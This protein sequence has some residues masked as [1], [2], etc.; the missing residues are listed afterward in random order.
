[1]GYRA[2]ALSQ[3]DGAG[4]EQI[5]HDLAEQLG[6]GYLNEAVI[7][8]VAAD[9]GIDTSMVGDAERRRSFLERLAPA[10]AFAGVEG[11]LPDVSMYAMYAMDHADTI[12]GF[13]RAAVREAADRGKVVLVS[14][15]AC[16]ACADHPDV[17]RVCATAS[18]PT[19]ASR[20][21]SDRGISQKDSIKLL[22]Q[23]D[24]GRASYLKRV[25]GVESESPTD[26]DIVVNTDRLDPDAAITAI[27]A[28]AG[29]DGPQN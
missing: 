19:R 22:R 20:V 6:F 9:Q 7:A 24:A 12:L 16:Y 23:S 14:H 8:T 15:A 11:I 29:A 18:L 26:Y 28:L 10:T 1:M 4:G 2:I 13:I 25:Y 27:L 3:V 5:G 21:A 17:L